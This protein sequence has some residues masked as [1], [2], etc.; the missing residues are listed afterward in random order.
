MV[1]NITWFE[2]LLPFGIVVVIALYMA[3]LAPS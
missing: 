2:L 1:R 3:S